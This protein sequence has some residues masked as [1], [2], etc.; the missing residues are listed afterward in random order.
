MVHRNDPQYRDVINH[1]IKHWQQRVPKP[2]YTC[3]SCRLHVKRKPVEI[4]AIKDMVRLV[5]RMVDGEGSPKTKR[6]NRAVGSMFDGFF[7]S[8]SNLYV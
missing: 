7:P 5:S 6:T 4:F 8:K 2:V 3:P 1:Y